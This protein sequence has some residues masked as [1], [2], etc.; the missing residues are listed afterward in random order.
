MISSQAKDA[1][2]IGGGVGFGGSVRY[3]GNGGLGGA[4]A[5]GGSGGLGG[6]S[7]GGGGTG[8]SAWGMENEKKMGMKEKEKQEQ[9]FP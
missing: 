9:L 8:G 3:R 1:G 2:G 5:V 4:P 7:S 6:G